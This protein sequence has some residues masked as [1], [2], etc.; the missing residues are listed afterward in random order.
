M[1]KATK[2]IEEVLPIIIK[3]ISNGE[4]IATEDIVKK[5]GV[6]SSSLKA[7]MKALRELFYGDYIV[8]DKSTGKWVGTESSFLEKMLLKPEEAVLLTAILRTKSKYGK[9]LEPWVRKIVENYVKRTKTSVFKQDVLEPINED[10]EM[11]F[12]QVKHAIEHKK[13]VKFT[14]MHFDTY[15]VFYPY[16]IINLEYYWYLLGYEE[17]SESERA[18]SQ[19]VKTYTMAKIRNFGILND[20][21]QYD[22]TKTQKQLIHTMNAFFQPEKEALTVELLVEHWL[23]DYIERAPYFSGWKNTKITYKLDDIEYYIYEVKSTDSKFRDITPAILRYMPHIRVKENEKLIDI[24]FDYLGKFSTYH[25]KKLS[26][27]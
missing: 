3:R 6:S 19:I 1:P 23:V 5:Y 4:P 15:N 18:T 12:A 27:T 21:F 20:T 7:H 16:K 10:M 24:I 8:P 25:N 2:K 9:G 13:K 14:Y 22:F 17:S 11:L 26:D